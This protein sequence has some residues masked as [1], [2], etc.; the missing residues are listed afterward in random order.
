MKFVDI[1]DHTQAVVLDATILTDC[2][3]EETELYWR[4]ALVVRND[5]QCAIV[6]SEIVTFP[7]R[8]GMLRLLTESGG[9]MTVRVD[10]LKEVCSYRATM[11]LSDFI[12]PRRYYNQ[13]LI[14]NEHLLREWVAEGSA[15]VETLLRQQI[16]DVNK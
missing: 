4:S 3:C 15:P 9:E 2:G 11:A 16:E 1:L 8:D 7:E 14:R 12:A 13:R 6:V 10:T 5:G